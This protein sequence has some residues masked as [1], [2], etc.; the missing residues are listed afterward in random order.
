MHQVHSVYVLQ[1]TGLI[2]HCLIF[3]ACKDDVKHLC[4]GCLGGRLINQVLTRQVDVV[5]RAHS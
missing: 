5:T 3:H 1:K 2:T 4:Q